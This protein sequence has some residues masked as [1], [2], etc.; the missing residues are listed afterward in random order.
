MNR[1]EVT[2]ESC[3]PRDS[4]AWL[5]LSRGRIASRLWSGI[6]R[7]QKLAVR[8][9]P[10]D[11]LL[12]SDHPGRVSARNV[13]PGRVVSV[14]LVPQGA[15]VTLDVGIPLTALVTRRAVKDL[16]LKRGANVYA[17]VK[18]MAVV[19][20]VSVQAQF[21][22]SVA[23]RHGEIEARRLDLL[24]AVDRTGSLSAAARETG[25]TFRTAWDWIEAVNRAWGSPLVA[26]TQGGKGGGGTVLTAEGRALLSL[27]ESFSA[28]AHSRLPRRS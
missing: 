23:A 10:R 24:R 6:R 2:V 1:Y 25:I 15:H 4:C 22:V 5:K 9:D 11:V 20:D 18:A 14:R 7:G 8:I 13:L 12:C 16:G 28:A 17:L 19:P 21:R 26:R 3:E 27:V